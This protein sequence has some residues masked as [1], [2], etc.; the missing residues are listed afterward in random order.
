VNRIPRLLDDFLQTDPA[1]R[2]LLSRSAQQNSLLHH[3]RRLL[4]QP[5]GEHCLA[6]VQKGDSLV[7]YADTSAW[8]SRLRFLSRNLIRE[9]QRRDQAGIKQITVRIFIPDR[10]RKLKPRSKALLS[11]ENAQLL[12][13][14]A[15]SI[16]D[17]A[18]GAALIRLSR[19]HR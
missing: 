2:K 9:F 10:A 5:L 19:H 13:Q 7:L 14:T 1:I 4:P 18:L 15:E 8:A 3:V 17:P 16:G 6:A 11:K 12:Q